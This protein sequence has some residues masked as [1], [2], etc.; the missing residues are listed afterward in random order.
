MKC[1]S[2]SFRS[3]TDPCTYFRLCWCIWYGHS[4][5]CRVAGMRLVYVANDSS[6]GD[7]PIFTTTKLEWTGGTRSGGFPVIFYG[8][9]MY[10]PCEFG[11]RKV[12]FQ[13]IPLKQATI[14]CSRYS[15]WARRQS[16]FFVSRDIPVESR[17]G[18]N[19][20][21]K[22]PVIVLYHFRRK[23]IRRQLTAPSFTHT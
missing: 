9:S 7:G 6:R 15:R 5:D 17:L 16:V 18:I 2:M 3:A 4:H 13:D 12:T 19:R 14:P 21:I 11:D 10:E 22:R 1:E 23:L 20:Q 8:I